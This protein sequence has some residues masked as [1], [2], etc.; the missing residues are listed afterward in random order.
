MSYRNAILRTIQD[1]PALPA[2][3]LQAVPLLSNPQADW[4]A[5]TRIVA[6]DPSL[7][8]N[9]L[10]LANS[11]L[12]GA[13]T[14]IESIQDALKRLGTT[15]VLSMVLASVIE[16]H[17][18]DELPGYDMPAGELW[19]H[20]VSVA[21]ACDELSMTLGLQIQ[22]CAFTAGLLID[23]G[24]TVL[25]ATRGVDVAEVVAHG[26]AHDI[27]FDQAE[28]EVLGMDHAEA[29]ALLLERWG[30]PEPF[31]SAV[32]WHHQPESADA[33][34]Q[35]LVDLVHLAD[36]ICTTAGLGGGSDGLRYQV[37]SAAAERLK[38]RPQVIESTLANTLNRLDSVGDLLGVHPRR[39]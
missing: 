28:R 10:R 5:I 8:A 11:A 19:M 34:Q 36:Q 39:T 35:E 24:K 22:P 20:G 25:V 3:A 13:R 27:T 16:P 21:C 18:Q 6:H 2:M 4:S 31:L 9:T 12:L 23:I 37:S 38:I 17:E 14:P 7:A 33:S 32:R 30:L 29:G 26:R 1:L 15:R